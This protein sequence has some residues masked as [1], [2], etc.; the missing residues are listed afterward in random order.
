MENIKRDICDICHLMWQ[1][2]WVAAND[3]NVSV[4]VGD[5]VVCTPSGIS[6]REMTPD[7]LIVTDLHGN[8]CEGTRR[9]S[10]ELALHLKCYAMREDVTAVVHAHAPYATAFAA[11]N[12]AIDHYALIETVLN[13]GAVP[14][15]PYAAPG[16]SD[17]AESIAPFLPKHDAILLRAHGALTVGADLKTAYYRMDSLEHVAK[18]MLFAHQLGGAVELERDQIDALIERRESFYHLKGKHPGY[19]KY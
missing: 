13:L 11:A 16:T 15:A 7:I 17:V 10:T 14:V 3:G 4:R 8:V 5:H 6:K 1:Q 18:I 2:G 12:R 9:P 19:I